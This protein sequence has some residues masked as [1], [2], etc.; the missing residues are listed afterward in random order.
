MYQSPAAAD[1]LIVGGHVTAPIQPVCKLGERAVRVL[2]AVDRG[3]TKA[4]LVAEV[5]RK[6][7]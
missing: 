6:H 5:A 2:V 4:V 7:Q 3:Y 1:P